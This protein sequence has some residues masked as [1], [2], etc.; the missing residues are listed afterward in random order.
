MTKGQPSCFNWQWLRGGRAGLQGLVLA[1]LVTACQAQEPKMVGGITGVAYNYSQEY[2]VFVKVNGKTVATGLDEVKVGGVKGGGGMCCIELP[3]GAK[4][5]EVTLVFPKGKESKV[6]APIEKWWPDLAESA[7]VHI[8]PGHKVVME[9]RSIDLVP[10]SDLLDARIK[11]LGL[12]RETKI[13]G[14]YNTGPNARADG[15]E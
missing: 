6:V 15:V 11:E 1:L 14:I 8:L 10:R 12:K 2:V 4:T 7:I 3:L 9:V 13:K 5:A